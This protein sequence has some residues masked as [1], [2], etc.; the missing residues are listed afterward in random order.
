MQRAEIKSMQTIPP[1][2]QIGPWP[3]FS[4]EEVAAAAQVL[5]SGKVNYWTGNEGRLFE[6]EFADHFGAKRAVAMA[7]GTVTLDAALK[8]VGVGSGDEVVVTPRS[9]MA[10]ASSIVMAGA[11]PVWADI[12]RVNGNLSAE[13]IE[14]VL[15][16][17]TK[18]IM[19]VHIAGWP[20]DMVPI[21]NLAKSRGIAVIEDC[22]QAHGAEIDGKPVGTFGDIASWS[23]CQD[24][25]MSTAGEGGIV[26][27][28]REDL[29]NFCW[30]IKDHGK[31]FEAVYNRQHAPGFR[32]LHETFGGNWRMTEI[33]SAI[34]RIQ[35]R[36]LPEWTEIRT[37]N[38]QIVLSYVRPLSA[39]R[40]EEP[41]ANFKHA[42][43]KLYF[44]VRPEALKSDWSRDRIMSEVSALGAPLMSGSCCEMYL[45]KNFQDAGLAPDT[46]LPIAKEF[47]ETSLMTV[48]H[49]TITEEAAHFIGKSIASVVTV[50]TK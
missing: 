48:C 5:N 23:F 33:C 32:W 38:A 15:T 39:L 19:P 36:K 29:W 12:D 18:A 30:S 42:F 14:K 43:Y 2:I 28:D 10:S 4:P 24:K 20:C 26:T 3:S 45:E 25:I 13:T 1:T 40:V 22:A 50:A 34:G 7:N 8:A 21:M 31:S 16:P 49:P 46:R 9:F 35:L 47:T 44:H 6:K 27:T 41:A 17:K 11:T 37:R